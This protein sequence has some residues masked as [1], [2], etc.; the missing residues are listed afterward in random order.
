MVNA[1][2]VRGAGVSQH[3]VT[4]AA[5]RKNLDMTSGPDG[6]GLPEQGY[7][8]KPVQHEDMESITS[9]WNAEYGPKFAAKH[10]PPAHKPE[11]APLEQAQALAPVEHTH[12]FGLRGASVALGSICTSLVVLFGAF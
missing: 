2:V 4:W 10:A 8:G 11:P 1:A 9:D 12:S 5:W 3:Q 7:H 6:P